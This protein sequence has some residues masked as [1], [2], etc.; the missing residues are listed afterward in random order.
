MAV[1]T[2]VFYNI[3]NLKRTIDFMLYMSSGILSAVFI[4]SKD[5]ERIRSIYNDLKNHLLVMESCPGTEETRKMAQELHSQIEDIDSR[6]KI[7]RWS[8]A[9]QLVLTGERGF[10]FKNGG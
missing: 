5:E 4:I 2:W 6:H 7:N 1:R 8:R 3:L 10:G 9:M